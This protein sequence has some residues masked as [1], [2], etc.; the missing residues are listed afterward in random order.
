M[1]SGARYI[2]DYFLIVIPLPMNRRGRIVLGVVAFAPLVS[3]LIFWAIHR[4]WHSTGIDLDPLPAILI[5]LAIAMLLGLGL[6]VLFVLQ[7]L[8]DTSMNI[9]RQALWV[10]GLCFAGVLTLPLFWYRYVW[11]ASERAAG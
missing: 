11:R 9:G 2:D 3:L 10:R 6:V 8:R 7:V 5:V 1:I 4:Y